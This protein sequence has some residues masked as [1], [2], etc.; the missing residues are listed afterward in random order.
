MVKATAAERAKYV[1]RQKTTKVVPEATKTYVKKAISSSKENKFEHVPL[2]S[3]YTSLNTTLQAPFLINTIPQG[4]SPEQRDGSKVKL[5]NLKL[6]IQ[7]LNTV[8][9]GGGTGRHT[10]RFVLLHVKNPRGVAPLTDGSDVFDQANPTIVSGYNPDI[11]FSTRFKV[12]KDWIVVC[13]PFLATTSAA[14]KYY[15]K[16]N[17]KLDIIQ[18]CFATETT[19]TIAGIDKGA[20]YLYCI[21]DNAEGAYSMLMD[22]HLT[23]KDY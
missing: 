22:H 8:F 7:L 14:H 23:F 16:C 20:V 19:G 21:C 6:A 9:T 1:K 13:E 2:T 18:E 4:D 15:T 11:S 17:K 5:T 3:R 12:L 10:F